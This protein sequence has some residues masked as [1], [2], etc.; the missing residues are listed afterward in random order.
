MI[1]RPPRSTLFPYTTLF[2]SGFVGLVADNVTMPFLPGRPLDPQ[3][4]TAADRYPLALA[5]QAQLITSW[6]EFRTRFGDQVED[7]NRILANAIYGF[8][9]NG[10]TRCWVTR[11]TDLN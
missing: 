5:G 9:N 7:G 11:V 1:R 6:D 10:G 3:N 4:P 2:R 8:F